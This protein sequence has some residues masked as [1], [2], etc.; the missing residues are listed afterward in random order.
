LGPIGLHTDAEALLVECVDRGFVELQQ[1][2]AAGAHDI[3]QAVFVR[4]ATPCGAHGN[5][6]IV[7]ASKAS[8]SGAIRADKVGITELADRSLAI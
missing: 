1:R 8:A 5:G 6:K 4:I 7:C 2:L 3:G